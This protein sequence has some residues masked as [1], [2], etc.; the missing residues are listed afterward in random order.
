MYYLR[1]NEDEFGF[2]IEGVNNILSTDISILKDDY[3]LFFEKQ[4]EGVQFRLKEEITGSS[5]FDYIEPFEREYKA[6]PKTELELLI[7]ENERIK[8]EQELQDN[9]IITNMIANTEIFEMFLEI[10]PISVNFNSKE[11]GNNAM[12]EIYATLIIEEIKTID[13]VPSI[14]KNQVEESLKQL[15]IQI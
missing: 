13:Q 5:L 8:K 15:R 11:K 7:A 4:R 12:V 9:K 1:I 6:Q 3:N 2:A 14:I 10:M